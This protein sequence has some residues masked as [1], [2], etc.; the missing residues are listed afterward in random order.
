MNNLV[1][2]RKFRRNSNLY[3]GGVCW[4]GRVVNDERSKKDRKEEEGLGKLR[5]KGVVIS[6]FF[7]TRTFLSFIF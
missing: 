3:G 1:T 7:N 4:V 6:T 2:G 5:E